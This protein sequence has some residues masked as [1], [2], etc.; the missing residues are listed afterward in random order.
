MKDPRLIKLAD[1][2][3]NYST[4]VQPGEQVLVESKGE[5]TFNLT[6]EIVTAVANAGGLPFWYH[7][8]EETER[9]WVMN[10]SEPQLE[11]YGKMHLKMMKDMACYIAVRGSNNSFTMADLPEDRRRAYQKFYYKPVHLEQRV[12]RTRWVVLRYPNFAMAQLAETSREAFEDYYFNVCNVDYPRM[13]K[14]QDA[15]ADLMK[16]TDSVHIKGPGTDLRFSI[17]G[18]PPVK[19]AGKRNIPDGEVF[20]A[21]IRDSINGEITYNTPSLYESALFERV[22]LVFQKGKIVR[23]DCAGDSARLNKIFDTDPGARYV[24]E[25]SFGLNPNITKPMKDIL[26]DEKIFGSIHLTPGQCYDEAPNGNKSAVHWDMVLIQTKEYGGGEIHLDGQLVRKDGLF[27]HPA[28]K[29][30]L[31][32]KNLR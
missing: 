10:A 30:K 28:L 6:R 29:D 12:K 21:P 24:G 1:T 13:D 18:I 31:S 4:A 3:V 2:L 22:H 17:K 5:A 15:L 25:F 19:C 11:A 20:T 7:N 14:A 32:A 9:R 8:E 23:A 27:V 16:R 26:F